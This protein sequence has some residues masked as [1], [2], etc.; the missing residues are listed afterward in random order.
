M[1]DAAV[2]SPFHYFDMF[3]PVMP[4]GIPA[5]ETYRVPRVPGVATSD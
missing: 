1:R 3:G 4:V 5:K 2:F